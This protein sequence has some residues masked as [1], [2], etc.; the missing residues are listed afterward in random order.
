MKF[1]VVSATSADVPAA[2]PWISY[3]INDQ[4]AIDAG[5][6]PVG[7]TLQHQE[8][9]RHVLLSH[10]HLDHTGGLPLFLDNVYSPGREAVVVHGLPETLDS[11]QRDL[12]NGRIWPDFVELTEQGYPF[13]KLVPFQADQPFRVEGLQITPLSISHV[14]PTV[15]FLVDDGTAAV[16][17]ISDTSEPETLWPALLQVEHLQAIYLECSFPN[18]HAELARITQHL[19]SSRFLEAIRALPPTISVRAIHLKPRWQA[20]IQRE[21]QAGGDP[22]VACLTAGLTEW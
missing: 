18:E 15:A 21:L 13:L 6:L 5:A 10:A 20:V 8:Q 1:Q 9:I 4:L 22:R 7:L 2:Q 3:V 16:A 19:H 17:I 14:V 12:F 11:L